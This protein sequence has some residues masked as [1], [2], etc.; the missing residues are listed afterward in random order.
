[1]S[2]TAADLYSNLSN[3]LVV[4]QVIKLT[5]AEW[6]ITAGE[7]FSIELNVKN[8]APIASPDK[9]RIV[10]RDPRLEVKPT[11]YAQLAPDVMKLKKKPKSILD[12][13]QIDDNIL[14]MLVGSP[15]KVVLEPGQSH[16]FQVGLTAAKAITV[17]TGCPLA[18]C[19]SENPV[20]KVRAF[21]DLDLDA[22]FRI[23]SKAAELYPLLEKK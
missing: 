16:S 14:S 3:Y 8:T 18:A 4:E 5:K 22:F 2:T 9:P 1:M 23:T 21:A 13:Y 6:Y 7:Q 11:E 17:I 10:F 19:V 15:A 20:A 12:V